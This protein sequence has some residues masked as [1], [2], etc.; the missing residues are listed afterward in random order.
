VAGCGSAGPCNAA[1]DAAVPGGHVAPFVHRL[2]PG[3]SP[4]LVSFG[5]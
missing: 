2:P 3:L 4:S 5:H 1:H